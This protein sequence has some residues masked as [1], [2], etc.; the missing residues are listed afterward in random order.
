MTRRFFILFLFTLL[1][2]SPI[3]SQAADIPV[4]S[5]GKADAPVVIDDYSSLGCSHC[6]DFHLNTLPELR[7]DYI[8]KGKVRIVF[9]HFPL[10]RASVDA[11]LLVQCVPSHQ[12]WDA[13]TLLYF[14]QQKWTQ[15]PDYQNRLAGY[16]AMLGIPENET[17]KCLNNKKMRDAI[18]EGRLQAMK[19]LE[20]AGTPTLIF[21][22]KTRTVG[23][24]TIEQ[25]AAVM[26]QLK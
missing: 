3:A 22:G 1:G 11:A 24:Q 16:G 12:A 7:R 14:Q 5:L 26:N 23:S 13:I 17:K 2:I 6:A 20:I 18:L 4:I 10:D 9:H 15:D 25:V 21:N 19:K 8:D